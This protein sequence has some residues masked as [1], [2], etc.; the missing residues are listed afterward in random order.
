MLRRPL[1]P[2]QS[3]VT[4]S[5]KKYDM[6]IV[7]RKMPQRAVILQKLSDRADIEE[8]ITAA[9]FGD[10]KRK[11]NGKYRKQQQE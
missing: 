6:P 5:K 4:S 1:L 2:Y 9:R 8:F 11:N 3:L 10:F 7:I